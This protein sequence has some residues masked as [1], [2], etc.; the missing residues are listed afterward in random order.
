VSAQ[1]D[2]IEVALLAAWCNP[3]ATEC[4]D[5]RAF[6]EALAPGF[7]V[8]PAEMTEEQAHRSLAGHALADRMRDTNPEHF[9]W[10]VE[11]RRATW[12]E[13]VKVMGEGE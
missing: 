6:R 5:A 8:L 2:A 9:A 4:A 10:L 13:M 12:R 7:V 1:D 3:P 11:A